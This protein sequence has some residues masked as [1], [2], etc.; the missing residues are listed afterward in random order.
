MRVVA[1]AG[2][3]AALAE[4]AMVL[5]ALLALEAAPVMASVG[6][7]VV[8]LAAVVALVAEEEEEEEED[9]AVRCIRFW[10]SE[11]DIK[12]R[13]TA[14]RGRNEKVSAICEGKCE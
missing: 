3:V 11:Q 13:V 5:P 1:G 14:S 9:V 2:V 10:Q 12:K 7:A 8:A 4:V 6:V